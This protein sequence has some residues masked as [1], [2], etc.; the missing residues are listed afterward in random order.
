MFVSIPRI[1]TIAS[2]AF[3][4]VVR[5]RILYI[6]ILYGAFL[7]IA[8]RLLPEIAAATEAKILPDF[9]LAAMQILGVLSAIIVGTGLINKEILNRTIFV[10]VAKPVSRT[11]FVLGKHLGLSIVL[12]LMVALMSV[13]YYGVMVAN[14]ISTVPVELLIHSGLLCIQLSLIT[15][16]ALFF[17]VF[18]SSLLAM[19]MTVA[20]YLMGISSSG[21]V[22][23]SKLSQ[24]PMIEKVAGWLYLLLP[25]LSRLDLKNQVVYHLI[26]SQMA[27]L[28]SVGYGLLYTLLVLTGTSLIFSRREF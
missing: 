11:E 22:K 2:N 4:E 9:G 17:G 14:Q 18:T 26:P 10:L 12:V 13:M 24:N 7:L 5:D 8:A 21:M 15:A 3:L 28:A 25:D 23:F 1:L 19:L 20:I 27:L 6:L 16:I